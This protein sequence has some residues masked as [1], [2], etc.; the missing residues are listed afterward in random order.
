MKEKYTSVLQRRREVMKSKA[1][2]ER[3][4]VIAVF[5]VGRVSKSAHWTRKSIP[6]DLP[7]VEICCDFS[8]FRA[9]RIQRLPRASM[10]SWVLSQPSDYKADDRAWVGSLFVPDL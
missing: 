6:N 2:S 3:L 7:L 5:M 4:S 10:L 8:L 1:H 9:L